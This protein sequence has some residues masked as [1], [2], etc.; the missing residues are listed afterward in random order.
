MKWPRE[1]LDYEFYVPLILGSIVIGWSFGRLA[2]TRKGRSLTKGLKLFIRAWVWVEVLSDRV[3]VKTSEKL[4]EQA[5]Y[6]V[7]YMKDGPTL[8][9]YPFRYTDDRREEVREIY[10]TE[11]QRM[12]AETKKFEPI[13]NVVGLLVASDRISHITFLATVEELAN[14]KSGVGE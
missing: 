10:L 9:G 3:K 4:E 6:V 8:F 11:V 12:N 7:V 13:P 5:R 1:L 2:A 14:L